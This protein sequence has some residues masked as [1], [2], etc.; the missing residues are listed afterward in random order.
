MDTSNPN[1]S[2]FQ[3]TPKADCAGVTVLQTHA[4]EIDIRGI[5]QNTVC[6]S[7]CMR[8]DWRVKDPSWELGNNIAPNWVS[9]C[10]MLLLYTAVGLSSAVKD[11]AV[12]RD[13]A[14]SNPTGWVQASTS[15]AV[16]SVRMLYVLWPVLNHAFKIPSK[17]AS[18]R[19]LGA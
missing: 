1:L 3:K 7:T 8:L 16:V 5:L 10:C 14:G 2:S 9:V 4:S 11:R 17:D 13:V 6:C 18:W 12:V 19:P 15:V